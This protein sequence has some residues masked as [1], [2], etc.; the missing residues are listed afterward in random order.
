MSWLLL[1][2]CGVGMFTLGVIVGIVLYEDEEFWRRR[3]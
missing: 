2:A 1:F 3:F